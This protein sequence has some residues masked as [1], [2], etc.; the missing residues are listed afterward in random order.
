MVFDSRRSET[1][2]DEIDWFF[3]GL[4]DFLRVIHRIHRHPAHHWPPPAPPVCSSLADLSIVVVLVAHGADGGHA[5]APHVPLLPGGQLHDAVP[6][7][8]LAPHQRRKG[9]RRPHHLTPLA[10]P[11]LD[12]VD[13]YTHGN[14]AQLEG[15]SRAH[16]GARLVRDDAVARLEPLRRDDVGVALDHVRAVVLAAVLD[17]RDVGGAVGVVLEPLDDALD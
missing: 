6:V 11:E 10:G 8:G 13:L 16:G 17:E 1:K 9:A 7:A 15:V 3:F 2:G 12:I 4:L 5:L 14:V